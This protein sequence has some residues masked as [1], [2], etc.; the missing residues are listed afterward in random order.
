MGATLKA[1][2]QCSV[3]F[4]NSRAPSLKQP[5][6]IRLLLGKKALWSNCLN[7]FLCAHYIVPRGKSHPSGHLHWA[8]EHKSHNVFIRGLAL[9][10]CKAWCCT[11]SV[12][13]I[14]IKKSKRDTLKP[15]VILLVYPPSKQR[16]WMCRAGRI[17]SERG[18]HVCPSSNTPQSWHVFRG[19]IILI[20][21][22]W[23]LLTPLGLPLMQ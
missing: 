21:P 19:Q 8:G 17:V 4:K 23:E 16:R 13:S 11:V 15:F 3:A 1:Q 2:Q 18:L 6:M 9:S 14:D 22:Y 12:G 20:K 7:F 5:L 10:C